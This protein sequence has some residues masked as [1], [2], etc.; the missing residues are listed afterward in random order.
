MSFLILSVILQL[1]LL[2]ARTKKKSEGDGDGGV[3]HLRTTRFDRILLSCL[4]SALA[5]GVASG[6]SSLIA[7][8]GDPGLPDF[9]DGIYCLLNHGTVVKIISREMYIFLRACNDLSMFSWG[10]LIS[11]VALILSRIQYRQ[12]S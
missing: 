1:I 4:I 7:R 5:L 9:R 10:L 6:V 2:T 12:P 3:T 11:T 8:G